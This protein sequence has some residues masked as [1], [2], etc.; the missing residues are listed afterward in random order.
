MSQDR[1]LSNSCFSRFS[2]NR[3]TFV[4]SHYILIIFISKLTLTPSCKKEGQK[5]LFG[6]GRRSYTCLIFGCISASPFQSIFLGSCHW[7][8]ATKAFLFSFNNIKGYNPVKLTQYR[9]QQHAMYTC[10]SHGPT[11]GSGHDI[12]IYDD[13]VNNQYSYTEC[14]QTYSNPAGY[15]GVNC[16]FFTG[17]RQFTPS[18]I[19]VFFEIG[20]LLYRNT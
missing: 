12:R 9:Y 8:Y 20:K 15:S 5:Q 2:K 4:S 13:A 17:S 7:S 6:A 16:G 3:S 19:E 14:G 11:F 10:S 18:D 1:N